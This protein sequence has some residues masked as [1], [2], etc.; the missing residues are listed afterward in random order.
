MFFL[1]IRLSFFNYLL[2]LKIFCSIL[3]PIS[4]TKYIL[5][6]SIPCINSSFFLSFTTTMPSWRQLNISWYYWNSNNYRRFI[7]NRCKRSYWQFKRNIEIVENSFICSYLSERIKKTNSRKINKFSTICSSMGNISYSLK[8][9][10][11]A[12]ITMQRIDDPFQ[13]LISFLR[14]IQNIF[15]V[16]SFLKLS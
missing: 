7:K 9:L 1:L 12:Y 15:H 6:W 16:S 2:V 3:L 10:T 11:I 4:F 13:L 14:W 8:Y 5:C